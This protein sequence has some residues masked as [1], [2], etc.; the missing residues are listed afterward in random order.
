MQK[1]KL[2]NYLASGKA[3]ANFRM[4][5][6]ISVLVASLLF[7]GVVGAEPIPGGNGG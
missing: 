7:T 5:M 6:I 2:F 4:V 1:A 3:A